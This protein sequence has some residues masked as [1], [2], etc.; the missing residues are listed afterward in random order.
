MKCAGS[1][2]AAVASS[3]TGIT[4][5]GMAVA[6]TLRRNRKIT[7]TTSTMVIIRVSFT[8]RTDARM[9]SVRSAMTSMLMP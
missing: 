5:D 6:I 8:S 1:I 7:Q 4:A 9:V 2:T 3:D